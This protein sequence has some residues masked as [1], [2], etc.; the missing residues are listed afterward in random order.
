MVELNVNS[1]MQIRKQTKILILAT[2]VKLILQNSVCIQVPPVKKK[3]QFL[4]V[5]SYVFS[6]PSQVSVFDFLFLEEV[7]EEGNNRYDDYQHDCGKRYNYSC[8]NTQALP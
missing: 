2:N 8:S 6:S 4:E 7:Y 1:N 3:Q 5:K